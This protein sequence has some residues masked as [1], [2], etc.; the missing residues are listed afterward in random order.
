MHDIQSEKTVVRSSLVDM[1]GELSA[2][3]SDLEGLEE[4]KLILGGVN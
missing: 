4:F 3:S 1:V 2:N